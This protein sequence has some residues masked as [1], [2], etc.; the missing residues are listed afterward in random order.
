VADVE[1]GTTIFVQL[2]EG[3]RPTPALAR[4]LA[5][6]IRTRLLAHENPRDI[7]FIEELPTTTTGKV[8]RR[9]LRELGVASKAI[10]L[11][12]RGGGFLPQM[13]EGKAIVVP[14][15]YLWDLQPTVDLKSIEASTRDD[16]FYGEV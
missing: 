12:E 10:R 7:K 16:H 2:R 8:R 1:I 11:D 5:E 6:Y 9:D 13:V 15:P 4:E 14:K 3:V